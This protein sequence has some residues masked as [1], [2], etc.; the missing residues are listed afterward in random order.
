MNCKH[1]GKRIR[2]M[3]W[4]W[5][6]IGYMHRMCAKNRWWDEQTSSGD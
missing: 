1:C 3:A 6:G 5:I 4:L 2:G